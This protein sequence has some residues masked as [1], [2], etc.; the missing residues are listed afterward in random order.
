MMVQGL[1]GNIQH[2]YTITSPLQGQLPV[3]LLNG[4]QPSCL[5]MPCMS[6]ALLL[7]LPVLTS[8]AP[9]L[10]CCADVRQLRHQLQHRV[11]HW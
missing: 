7:H 4:V 11:A 8:A 5:G 2:S 1:G 9:H 6:S 3:P 10:L